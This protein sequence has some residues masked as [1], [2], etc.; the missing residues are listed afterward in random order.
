MDKNNDS[1]TRLRQSGL[2]STKHRTAILNMLK[3]SNMPMP[4]E[5][6]YIQLKEAGNSINLSTVYRTL[7]ALTERGLLNKHSII[8]DSRALYEY[9][10][11]V[12]K[13]FLVCMGCKKMLTIEH[14]PLEEYEKILEKETDFIIS[15]HKLDLYGYC[16][17]CQKNLREKSSDGEE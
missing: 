6:I 11:K 8:N 17:D 4:A 12:H 1:I 14:C 7:E 2:K 16:A 5:K 3:Q 10:N 13:H 15:G 9:N